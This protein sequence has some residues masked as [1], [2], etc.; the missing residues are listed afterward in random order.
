M[1]I[2]AKSNT[3]LADAISTSRGSY[4]L[5]MRLPEGKTITAGRLRPTIFPAGHYAYVGSALGGFRSRLNRHL[6]TE[7]KLHWHIDYLLQ[8]A[9][10]NAIIICET[11]ERAECAIAKTL[12]QQFESVPGFGASD[13][14]CESHLFFT[15]AD[16]TLPVISA[17]EA[18]GL[19]SRLKWQK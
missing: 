13:C 12:A 16:M 18:V 5:L 1:L 15:T 3:H 8:H 7:K 6:R 4:I 9:S 2:Q 11:E 19:E 10:L 14:H 17:L